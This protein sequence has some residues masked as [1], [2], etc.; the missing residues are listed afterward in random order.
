MDLSVWFALLALFLAGGL[1]PGP[2][3]MMVMST[4]L[5]YGAPTAMIPSLGVSAAN[6]V[7]ITLAATGLAAFA[8]TLPMALLALKI[9]GL[10]FI[11]WLAWGMVTA[12]P[13]QPRARADQ[14]PARR[15]LFGRGIG[16][17]LL[18]PNAFVFFGLLLPG[19]FDPERPVVFQALVMMVTITL[20]ELVGLTVYAWLAD[21]MNRRFQSPAFVRLFNRFS[22]AAMVASAAFAAIST[23]AG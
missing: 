17:Q 5:R 19:Y 9:A 14:A 16:L 6:L 7:W 13:H 12:D 21:A 8:A 4:S 18:N 22:A 3:V 10:L 11:L 2:A 23:T 15:D 1:T 20:T